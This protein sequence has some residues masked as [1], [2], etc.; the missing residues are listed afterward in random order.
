[1]GEEGNTHARW[2]T[3][4]PCAVWVEQVQQAMCYEAAI[5]YWRRIKAESDAATI[6]VLYWQMN[7]IWAVRSGP[8]YEK[9]LWW[10]WIVG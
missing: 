6:G 5:S 10:W 1:M 2:V 9:N 8:R 4:G 7:D 3:H